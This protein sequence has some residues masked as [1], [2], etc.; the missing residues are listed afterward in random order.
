MEAQGIDHIQ[1]LNKGRKP[2][3]RKHQGHMEHWK[4]GEPTQSDDEQISEQ[5]SEQDSEQNSE[6]DSERKNEQETY[7]K[8]VPKSLIYALI[9]EM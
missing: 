9:I 6:Q 4:Q 2:P 3:D 1:R 7:V 8:S 5:D